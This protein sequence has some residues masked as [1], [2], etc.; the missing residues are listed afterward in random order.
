MTTREELFTAGVALAREF[1][2]LNGI[3]MPEIRRLEPG[4][5][6]FNIG[7]CAYYRPTRITIMVEKC[8]NRGMGGRAWSWPGYVIDRT[9]YGVIQHE[10]GH[11]IDTIKTGE[12]TH[13][14]VSEKHFAKRICET[15]GED[16]LTGYLG[17]DKE[18]MTYHMEWFAENFRLFVTNPGLSQLLRPKFYAAMRADGIQP[19]WRGDW[20]Q[21]LMAN[22]APSRITVQARKKIAAASPAMET[23]PML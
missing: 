13:S 14:D 19:I 16:P 10:L 20:D 2:T 9:P 7:T 4:T 23:A 18:E 11:H 17:T 8:A 22:L 1:C 15:S 6:D 5:R 12:V 21:I 3:T